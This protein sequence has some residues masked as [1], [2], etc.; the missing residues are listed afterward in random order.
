[1]SRLFSSRLRYDI[2]ELI[3][4]AD[5]PLEIETR[6]RDLSQNQITNLIRYLESNDMKK[7]HSFTI[8]Y[9]VD[10][11]RITQ[12][13]GNY[14]YITKKNLLHKIIT[15]EDRNIKIS[16]AQESEETPS[17]EPKN[18][19]RKR[20]KD[21]VSYEKNNLRVDITKVND[22]DVEKTEVELEVVDSKKFD[23]DSYEKYIDK[24]YQI[25]HDP[26]A[27]M[28]NYLNQKLS[29]TDSDDVTNISKHLSRAR[30]LLARD[31]TKQGLLQ[32]YTVA[33][34][35]D[36]TQ[37]LMIFWKNNI[38]LFY[39][40]QEFIFLTNHLKA[41]WNNC[42]LVGEWVKKE[43]HRYD[44]YD[45][46]YL[47]FDMLVYQNKDVS[48]EN[49]LARLNYLKYFYNNTF[50]NTH[51][52]IKPYLPCG[53]EITGFY[54]TVRK[55]MALEEDSRFDT[56]G[57]IFTPIY[58]SYVTSGQKL[59]SDIMNQQMRVLSKYKDVCKYKRP[60]NLT[61]DFLVKKDGLYTTQ[62]K[63]DGTKNMPFTKDNYQIEEKYLD[64]IV[65]F[66]PQY[67]R[68]NI[69]YH[70]IRIRLDKLYPNSSKV[71]SD[72][73]QLVHDPIRVNTIKGKSVQ[74]MR[75]YHNQIKQDL[76]SNISGLVIDI[77]A[78]KGGVF[79][80]YTNNASIG[81]VLSIE[82][83]KEFA[84]EFEKRRA[85]LK[86]PGQF[87]LLLAGGEEG[88]RIIEAARDFFPQNLGDNDLNICFHISLS[89]F[90]KNE[91]MLKMLA[92]TIQ[93]IE[94]FY[95]QREGKGK[96]RIVYLTIEGSRVDEMFNK[97]GNDVLLNDIQMKKIDEKEIF[98]NIEDS[99]TVHD[100]TEYLVRLPQLW[101]L[102]GFKPLFE[103]QA[104]NNKSNGYMLSEEELIYSNLFV[105]GIAE[106]KAI[107]N[108][109]PQE[110]TNKC[111]YV[112]EKKANKTKH[113]M[114]AKGDDVRA[115]IK[116]NIYRVATMNSQG[117]LYHNLLKLLSTNYRA[118]D[119]FKRHQLAGDL[120]KKLRASQDLE[121]IAKRL[122]VGIKIINEDKIYNK[123]NSR[124]I[125]L[126]RCE[127][128]ALEP[129]IR[130]GIEDEAIFKADD[131]I[132]K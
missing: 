93:K 16:V 26:R 117:K 12:E 82:P 2:K 19:S 52:M 102:T 80:K 116:D 94:S 115:K 14:F 10:K 56:D 48:N 105:Y 99:A 125:L 86:N 49:Y 6:F 73:W 69:I 75:R 83:N 90:W 129:V 13:N 54:Q 66:S 127:D 114:I 126:Y 58:S 60:E 25:M 68:G 79:G 3:E 74:L 28:I 37:Q 67:I 132:L 62:G 70:P 110:I 96:I 103:Y 27:D 107:K 63:F 85:E 98:I 40:N 81:R 122:D 24:L 121:Y 36:G 88:D 76:L 47:P 130:Q 35:A 131:V 65:E 46:L 113:G 31:M 87:K 51:V 84:E 5:Y 32:N 120:K 22:N 33:L 119:V 78:G 72:N 71:A 7:S 128:G 106:R 101:R 64:K 89:F 59:P 41:E 100:Q 39:P 111:L 108:D 23:I 61:I 57:V 124:N 42:V 109:L 50:G 44:D 8:D 17:K 9:Y 97:L 118:S 30:D 104:D 38:W 1:M 21:R 43:N 20:I 91:K 4:A 34:K 29:Q 55:M 92:E 77:G 95:H 18:Y 112:N 53:K 11:K 15:T 45:Y 123:G